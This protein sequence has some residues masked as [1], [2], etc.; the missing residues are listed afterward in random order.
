MAIDISTLNLD[1]ID[2]Q[3]TTTAPRTV[4]EPNFDAI[5]E[6]IRRLA[7]AV[8]AIPSGG[9]GGTPTSPGVTPNA[10]DVPVASNP[11][12]GLNSPNVQAALEELQ[13]EILAIDTSHMSGTGLTGRQI[14]TLAAI[15]EAS[16]TT[17]TDIAGATRA[18]A[19]TRTPPSPTGVF[20]TFPYT[21]TSASTQRWFF[22]VPATG[23]AT[24][25]DTFLVVRDADDAIVSQ[26]DVSAIQP[27][28]TATP[29]TRRYLTPADV[30]IPAGGSLRLQLRTI[31][32]DSYTL[33]NLFRVAPG[34]LMGVSDA[35]AT[36]YTDVT[37]VM[38]A[39]ANASP[40]NPVPARD[41]SGDL[42][43]D[44]TFQYPYTPEITNNDRFIVQVPTGT[45][46]TGVV[47][48]IFDAAGTATS[49]VALSTWTPLTTAPTGFQWY[50]T[51]Q[52]VL[53]GRNGSAR[54]Q[55]RT[56]F[57]TH[58]LADNFRVPTAT[59][60]G[61]VPADDVS[62]TAVTDLTARNVQDAIAELKGDVDGVTATA[63]SHTPTGNL[64]ATNVQTALTELQTEVDGID[65]KEGLTPSQQRSL[66]NI[67]EGEA[68]SYTTLPRA[69][70]TQPD[71]AN[72]P[73]PFGSFVT[74]ITGT[75]LNTRW[76]F[77]VPTGTSLE[78]LFLVRRDANGEVLTDYALA[79]SPVSTTGS[80]TGF[81]RYFTSDNVLVVL[82]ETLRIQT[83]TGTFDTYT[84]SERYRLPGARHRALEEITEA[85]TQTFADVSAGRMTVAGSQTN[86]QPEGTFGNPFTA[87]SNLVRRV[88]VE[89][90]AGTP[91]ADLV[92]RRFFGGT[93]ADAVYE[94]AD[95]PAAPGAAPG[96]DRYLTRE[97]VPIRSGD[98][99]RVQQ[100][101]SSFDTYTLSD[102]YRFSPS[103]LTSQIDL[104]NLSARLRASLR[105]AESEIYNLDA[106][107]FQAEVTVTRD[108]LDAPL[109]AYRATATLSDTLADYTV[110]NSSAGNH[111]TGPYG[112]F[113]YVLVPDDV[114][115][116]S[117]ITAGGGGRTV[118]FIYHGHVIPGFHAFRLDTATPP[119]SGP[120]SN[121]LN[122]RG[123]AVSNI[124][125]TF[126]DKV[127]IGEDNLETPVQNRLVR[128]G[129]EPLFDHVSFSGDVTA[130][131]T[132]SFH[133]LPSAS[134]PERTL[135]S[136]TSVTNSQVPQPALSAATR[137]TLLLPAGT[138]P[139]TI[140]WDRAPT[141]PA[142]NQAAAN[143]AEV[144][145]SGFREIPATMVPEGYAG[146]EFV[147]PPWNAASAV[148]TGA[149]L[150]SGVISD[151]NVQR[152]DFDSTVKVTDDNLDLAAPTT[153][154][155]ASQLEKLDN[156][157]LKTFPQPLVTSGKPSVEYDLLLATAWPDSDVDY[158]SPGQPIALGQRP[159][160]TGIRESSTGS[161]S[162]FN[163]ISDSTV[164]PDTP[165]PATA[166][167]NYIGQRL[168]ASDF[169]GGPGITG[170]TL[171]VSDPNLGS[172]LR[173]DDDEGVYATSTL[174]VNHA[175]PAGS[176]LITSIDSPLTGLVLGKDAQ[177]DLSLRA[178]YFS[179]SP[180]TSSST[181][182]VKRQLTGTDG[183]SAQLFR[184]LVAGTTTSVS[185]SWEFPSDLLINSGSPAT[186]QMTIRVWSD[187]GD[188]GV[189]DFTAA[190]PAAFQNL[191]TLG[192][193]IAP[194]TFTIDLAGA[195]FSGAPSSITAR[196]SL[197]AR[198][199]SPQSAG[200][201]TLSMDIGTAAY[202]FDVS[203]FATHN[204]SVSTPAGSTLETNLA[205]LGSG[206]EDAAFDIGLYVYSEPRP[207]SSTRRLIYIATYN[208]V[209][210]NFIGTS[211]PPTT[212]PVAVTFGNSN[213]NLAMN[214]FA[215]VRPKTGNFQDLGTFTD[216]TRTTLRNRPLVGGLARLA[217]GQY[218]EVFTPAYKAV[219][220]TNRET[221]EL[222]DG[223]A[224]FPEWSLT[225]DSPPE[226][227]Q[228]ADASVFQ[229]NTNFSGTVTLGFSVSVAGSQGDRTDIATRAYILLDAGLQ[230][231]LPGGAWTDLPGPRLYE[232]AITQGEMRGRTTDPRPEI[233]SSSTD[234]VAVKS[235][236][237]TAAFKAGAEYRVDFTAHRQN[238]G[239][240]A[241]ATAND[242][243]NLRS[244]GTTMQLTVFPTV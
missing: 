78:N 192:I 198:T 136:W 230:E 37:G 30:V 135:A 13:R 140:L 216:L 31:N 196:L 129:S 163:I 117:A 44:G 2:R 25:T 107:I 20:L 16:T 134:L 118:P 138:H 154:L 179:G 80:S 19:S 98:T 239:G 227:S 147:M 86:P 234:A 148:R 17:Y 42:T 223:T 82:G 15:A 97:I 200:G 208:G 228:T 229:A 51:P 79:G 175:L 236:V 186:F 67:T 87:T 110:Y 59:L 93:T 173:V 65:R 180:N 64:V 73:Q 32:Y 34:S 142:P 23:S 131:A 126:S 243:V 240:G 226:L 22:E 70:I 108:V 241:W 237:T 7:V 10:S 71:N 45:S 222:P 28:V 160:Y 144:T 116:R 21:A 232:P 141:Q 76:F 149:R 40:D 202:S 201:L 127:K 114:E 12:N 72:P 88:F 217:G 105:S 47:W 26:L 185:N 119:G 112:G 55:I 111:Y 161:P 46:L 242:A 137:Y 166:G 27:E 167:V 1:D 189:H 177:G 41:I 212:G 194:T 94:L 61:D 190:I 174:H 158:L 115:L 95:E 85:T 181:R 36:S 157:Q 218:T 43:A 69:Q 155:T 54:V 124:N 53:I 231:K 3:N 187:T 14:R 49:E 89:V 63:V 125:V 66:M 123:G 244:T 168:V 205:H 172:R 169:A 83:R 84:L 35:S 159:G 92:L 57:V 38:I 122:L 156:L 199:S 210:S 153:V 121:I 102:K 103:G 50:V 24:L 176:Y 145:R 133:L 171:Q 90:P 238:A 113:I 146:F 56:D 48:R 193:P 184:N 165:V 106:D 52:N 120:H 74:I 99:V 29:L 128:T 60:T 5:K 195:G 33:S 11:A 77:E 225:T 224:V 75:T 62:L 18:S 150:T 214:R 68:F 6:A 221:E 96:Y 104:P 178:R 4:L 162:F 109:G 130:E 182:A 139:E 207:G 9:S 91:K 183:N 152:I 215:V 219:A 206:L 58:T 203:M 220:Y 211:A 151:V 197:S 81:D 204:R 100:R 233:T 188:Q 170:G 39:V 235:L 191:T 164:R 101:T 209:I 143:T 132:T 8:N 213:T